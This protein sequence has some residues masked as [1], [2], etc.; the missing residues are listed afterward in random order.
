MSCRRW[1][2]LK[3]AHTHTRH[4]HTRTPC[5]GKYA[6]SETTPSGLHVQKVLASVRDRGGTCAVVECAGP[7]LAARSCE[8]VEM[9]VVVHTRLSTAAAGGGS[10]AALRAELEL[11]ERLQDPSSQVRGWQGVGVR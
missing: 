3:R 1:H 7:A 8:W 5:A 6:V 4:A 10:A 9:A 11:F 2:T